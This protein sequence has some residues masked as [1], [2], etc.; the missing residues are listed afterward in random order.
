MKIARLRGLPFL[1]GPVM[2]GLREILFIFGFND[3]SL[4]KLHF[5]NK[6]LETIVN[7]HIFVCLSL[8]TGTSTTCMILQLDLISEQGTYC[9]HLCSISFTFYNARV[10][11]A[12]IIFCILCYCGFYWCCN[13]VII[14]LYW[15]HISSL[16][17][18]HWVW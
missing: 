8:W 16:C 17:C 10:I 13:R 6:W 3:I 18:L 7:W 12:F 15:V 14:E 2:I 5:I 11:F 9:P 1:A 4:T